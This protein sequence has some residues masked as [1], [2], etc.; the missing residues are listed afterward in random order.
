M[1]QVGLPLYFARQMK[2]THRKPDDLDLAA[3]AAHQA[4]RLTFAVVYN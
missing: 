4:I 1:M 2:A 3:A